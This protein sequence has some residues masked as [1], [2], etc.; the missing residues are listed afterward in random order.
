MSQGCFYNKLTVIVVMS[1][2]VLLGAPL[3]A[4]DYPDKPI[5]LIVP[6]A[7]GG[8]ADLVARVFG[9]KLTERTKQPVIVDNRAGGGGIVAAEYAARAAPDGYT[10]FIG[11]QQPMAILP[12]LHAN[13]PYDPAADFAPVSHFVS[14]PLILV[15]HPSL[16][17]QSVAELVALAKAKPGTLSYGSAG[18]ASM[19][20]LSA[21]QFKLAAGI[22]IVHVPYKGVAPA[23]QDLLSGH[24]ALTFDLVP[25]VTE[26][27]RDGRLR[28]LAVTVPQRVTSMPDIPT[29]AELGWPTVQAS[30]WFALFAPAK[31][32]PAIIAWLNHEATEIFTAPDVRQRF[33]A[34]SVTIPLGPPEALGAYATAERAR[35]RELVHR[36]N[37]KLE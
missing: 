7:P 2:A 20:Q 29:M 12:N 4:Q 5:R 34:Q 35:W 3:R 26:Q 1:L 33:E 27:V 14:A 21:E 28:A 8:L 24:L 18:I 25:N 19:G 32:P 6:T 31:T 30:N 15:V 36:A 10:L 23:L 13:L 22:D 37:I 9:Q 17:A 16:P 11:A